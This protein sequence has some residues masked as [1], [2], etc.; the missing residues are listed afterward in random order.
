MAN[1]DIRKSAN[2]IS[3]KLCRNVADL[4][5]DSLDFFENFFS[6]SFFSTSGFRKKFDLQY[7]GNG[8]NYATAFILVAYGPTGS[9]SGPNGRNVSLLV[10][11]LEGAKLRLFLEGA[12]TRPGLSAL[13]S[14][15]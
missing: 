13:R 2:R 8:D 10:C 14:C 5:P 7:L 11:P 3:T 4:N 9:S 12:P 6:S 1:C 15:V